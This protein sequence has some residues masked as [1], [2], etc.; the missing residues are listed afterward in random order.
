MR[1]QVQGTIQ[2]EPRLSHWK[3]KNRGTK[4]T[5]Y[6]IP[7]AA[8]DRRGPYVQSPH[9][10]RVKRCALSLLFY[11]ARYVF[12]TCRPAHI[13]SIVSGDVGSCRRMV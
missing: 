10:T 8:L 9:D 6:W 5:W 12:R 1:V 11:T 3:C 4:R 2:V 7:E 13:R